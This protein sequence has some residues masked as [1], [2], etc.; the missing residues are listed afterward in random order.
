MYERLRF[1]SDDVFAEAD[2]PEDRRDRPLEWRRSFNLVQF[3]IAQLSTDTVYEVNEVDLM[4]DV[5]SPSTAEPKPPGAKVQA[6]AKL[7]RRIHG[8]VLQDDMRDTLLRSVRVPDE[9]GVFQLKRLGGD[10]SV[11][12]FGSSPTAARGVYA[13]G[14]FPGILFPAD[15]DDGGEAWTLEIAIPES[16]MDDLTQR[17]SAG[18]INAIVAAIALQSFSDEVDDALREWHNRRSLFIHASTAAAPCRS[19]VGRK[20]A[21]QNVTPAVAESEESPQPPAEMRTPTVPTNV[22]YTAVLNSIKIALWTLA[23]VEVIRLLK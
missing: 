4:G 6:T 7:R 14:S 21:P 1:V 3:E 15:G 18:E 23:V 11:T 9:S 12:I 10:I 13:D 8:R 22:D 2:P 19:L 16:Q 5:V 20:A 17:L